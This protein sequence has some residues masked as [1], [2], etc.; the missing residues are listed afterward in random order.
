MR[1]IQNIEKLTKVYNSLNQCLL[2]NDPGDAV[3]NIT[4]FHQSYDDESELAIFTYS[5]KEVDLEEFS[6]IIAE[7]LP[8]ELRKSFIQEEHLILNNSQETLEIHFNDYTITAIYH[9]TGQW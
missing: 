9:C 2:S 7:Y 3:Y 6:Q 4:N 8:E 1:Y 5:I